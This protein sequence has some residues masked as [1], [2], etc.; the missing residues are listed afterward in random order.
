MSVVLDASALLTFL[1]GE[2]GSDPVAA[3]LEGAQVSTVNWSEVLQKS[4]HR[5]VDIDG[6]HQSFVDLGVTFAP[7]SVAHAEIAAQLWHRTRHHGL[8][9]ADRACL[10]LAMDAALPVMTADRAW[11]RLNLELEIQLLR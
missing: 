2:R 1:Q 8:S 9:L 10:A 3:A 4:L 5:N 6:M 11:S 7:Y